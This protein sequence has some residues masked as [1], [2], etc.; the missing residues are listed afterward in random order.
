MEK[1]K[2]GE[3]DDKF[4]TKMSS[5]GLIYKYF[6]KEII[7]S[8]ATKWNSNIGEDQEE[9]SHTINELILNYIMILLKKLTQLI[10]EYLNLKM[11]MFQ[12]IVSVLDLDQEYRD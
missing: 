12:D 8:L 4:A 11:D 2:E 3:T 10:M 6:G 7:A 1:K 9:I 5:A